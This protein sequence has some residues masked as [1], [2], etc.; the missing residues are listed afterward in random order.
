MGD[1]KSSSD[2]IAKIIKP[3][4]EIAFQ[5]NILA[6]NA[7]VEAA[8]AGEAGAGFAVVAEEVRNLAQRSAVA[9]KETA[10]KIEAAINKTALGVQ[11]TDKVSLT[12]QAIVTQAGKVDQLAAEVATASKE[13]MQGITQVNS[14]IS[15]IDK[16]TQSNA[17]SAEE[18]ASAAEEMSAQTIVLKD[19]VA[20]L[21]AMVKGAAESTASAPAH[22]HGV[23]T[24]GAHA[25]HVVKSPAI[26]D[27]GRNGKS[28][29][30][31]SDWFKQRSG[32]NG[33]P[34]VAAETFSDAA[35]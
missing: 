5:T 12:L 10:T 28:A 9:S 22:A 20:E 15:E 30:V 19:S 35:N 8:R 18:S 11:L 16:V 3:I 7:A 25:A 14:A 33:A 24:A 13:Q 26:H 29:H 31:G 1:I 4:D 2:D 32:S 6:L 27:K 23:R 21:L 17:A 34:V